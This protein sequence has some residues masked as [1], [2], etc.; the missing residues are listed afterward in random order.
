MKN[1][2][3]DFFCKTFS[4]QYEEKIARFMTRLFSK[5]KQR[6][7]THANPVSVEKVRQLQVSIEF[8]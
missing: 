8:I 1:K 2:K 6:P 3:I 4:V 5:S 7:G